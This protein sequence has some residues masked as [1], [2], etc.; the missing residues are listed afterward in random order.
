[1][2]KILFLLIY[3]LFCSYAMAQIFSPP[4]GI[5]DETDAIAR[6]IHV[7]QCV[8]DGISCEKSGNTGV[9]TVA[10]GGSGDV[11][12]VGDCTGGACLDGTS[13]GGTNILLY[14]EQ[15]ATTIQIGDNSGAVTLTLPTTTGTLATTA[16]NVATASALAS[17]GANCDAG[18]YP[19]GVDASGAVESCTAAPTAASLAVDDLI[20]LSGVAGGEVHLS[21]FTGSTITD[22][23]TIKAAVQLLETAVETKQATVTEGSLA[24]SVIVSA[25]IKDGTI[26]GGDLA[27]NIAITS[28]G[29]QDFGGATSFELPNGANPTTDTAGQIAIDTDHGAYGGIEIYGAT[30]SAVLPTVHLITKTVYDPDGIQSTADAIPLFAVEAEAFEHGITL[31]DCG[32]KTNA[33]SSYTVNFEEW[34]APD[35]GSPATIESVATSSSLEAED[36]GTLT[37]GAIAAGSIIYADL[38]DT[39]IDMLVLW[40]TYIVNP[41]D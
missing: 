29:A 39:D 25:D 18:N 41:G 40:F 1:M 31:L 38:P 11:T 7:I 19:L 16:S 9:V 10:S 28:T 24:D 36:D 33:S 37:D 12:G 2:K 23:Q 35:D 4:L 21:T 3:L 30:G 15:G 14:D 27:S 8:G 5:Q 32:I 22:N 34:T 17:N 20:T 6:P 13:D 26:A